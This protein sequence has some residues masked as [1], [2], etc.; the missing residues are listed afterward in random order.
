MTEA[1]AA[2]ST[3]AEMILLH[4]ACELQ[5]LMNKHKVRLEARAVWDEAALNQGPEQTYP[6]YLLDLHDNKERLI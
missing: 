3:N 5:L 2:N 6:I 1:K 4:A